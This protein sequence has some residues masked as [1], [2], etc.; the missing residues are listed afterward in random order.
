M[1]RQKLGLVASLIA[2]VVSWALVLYQQGGQPEIDADTV[3]GINNTVLFLV[4]GAH[5]LSNVHFATIQALLERHPHIEVHFATAMSDLDS[6][7]GVH[8][9]DEAKLARIA[10]FARRVN[11]AA[12]DVAFHRLPGPSWVRAMYQNTDIGVETLSQPP[13]YQSVALLSRQFQ[14]CLAPWTGEEYLLIY[15]AARAVIDEVDPAVVVLD[16]LFLPGVDAAREA[17]RLRAFV[18]PNTLVDNFVADQPRLGML[19]KYP[20]VGADFG[21]PLPWRR[22]PENALSAVRFVGAVLN[23]PAVQAKQRFLQEHGGIREPINFYKLHRPNVPWVTQTT[24]GASIPVDVVPPN[25]TCAGPIVLSAAPAAEQDAELA[26]WL[27]RG[28][29]KTLLINLGSSVSEYSPQQAFTMA[30]AIRTTLEQH[31]DAQVLWKLVNAGNRTAEL[32]PLSDL[33]AGGRVR[34]SGWID[35]D[36]VSL[37]ETG[38]IVA[39]VHHGGSNC[40]HEAIYAGVPQVVLPLWADLYNFAAL[41]ETSGIGIYGSRGTAP[42][43]TVEGLTNAFM[44]VIDDEKAAGMREKVRKLSQ[45]AKARPGREKAAAEIARWAGSG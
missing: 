42:G 20:V 34:I 17:R 27:A 25:V 44:T 31:P 28:R 14:Q 38:D 41:A 11:P 30:A 33:V 12:G 1:S 4:T 13:G 5:G 16:T 18:T 36:P 6:T 40:Y 23:M 39:S 43:W 15:R 32:E 26:S 8:G 37:L 9:R 10:S 19:W 3:V 29:G 45:K 35:V 21:F 22:V 2:A 24:E 7:D